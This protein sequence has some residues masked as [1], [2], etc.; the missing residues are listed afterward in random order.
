MECLPV[1]VRHSLLYAYPVVPLCI[2]GSI[3]VLTTTKMLHCDIAH[4]S[5]AAL[6]SASAAMMAAWWQTVSESGVC[7]WQATVGQRFAE[8]LLAATP[9]SR[10]SVDAELVTHLAIAAGH[11]VAAAARFKRSHWTAIMRVLPAIPDVVAGA[12]LP[13]VPGPGCSK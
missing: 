6:V 7:M 2:C 11:P 8:L 13:L 10:N 1:G 5:H 3:T 4:V 12:R 9:R